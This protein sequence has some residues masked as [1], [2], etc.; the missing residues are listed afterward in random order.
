MK[1]TI[2]LHIILENPPEGVLYGLQKGKGTH[3]DCIQKQV[4]IGHD[5]HFTLSADVKADVDG[6]PDFL[7]IVFMV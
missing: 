6:A 5:L 4:A 1:K 2:Q 7:A 3:Y